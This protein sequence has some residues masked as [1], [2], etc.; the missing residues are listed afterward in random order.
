MLTQ[1]LLLVL[2]AAPKPQE[3]VPADGAVTLRAAG[4]PAAV[5]RARAVGLPPGFLDQVA[6]GNRRYAVAR[7]G[8]LHP[9]HGPD[10]EALTA[11]WSIDHPHHRGVYWAWPEVQWGE[12]TGDL[13]ALQEVF[14][15]PVGE[16][17]LRTVDG[18]AVLT[19]MNLWLWH[20]DEPLVCERVHVT[21]RPAADGARTV[22]LALSF[23]ALV[24]G[25]TLARRR[26]DLYGGLNVRLAPVAGLALDHHSEPNT[27]ERQGRA[28][29]RASG[30]WAGGRRVAT[31]AILEHPTNP[32][33]PGDFVTY[34]ELP[35]FQPAFPPA[36]TRHPLL[37]GERLVLRYRLLIAPGKPDEK[38][39]AARCDEFA[40]TLSPF[41][42]AP[43]AQ[44]R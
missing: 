24:P 19:A 5:Y 25:I 29:S 7:S 1:L 13:H 10:G 39:L 22:D 17:S 28:W 12:R 4:Q 27:A 42:E 32:G 3:P 43:P 35:W 23:Q 31:F 20:D 6:E 38:Q 41:L 36:G 16:P 18:A 44:K 2:A 21:A 9:L 33:F 30:T 14:A 40:A 15:R 34:P 26:T 37:L 11:D 8:Y